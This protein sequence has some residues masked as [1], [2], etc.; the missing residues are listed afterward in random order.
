MKDRNVVIYDDSNRSWRRSLELAVRDV[1][2]GIFGS[3]SL[4]NMLAWQD[5]RQRYRRSV[6]GPFWL[7]ISTAVMVFALG[8]LYS[9]LFK[10]PLA[11]Y[12]PFVGVGLIVWNLFASI[13]NESCTVFCDAESMIKQVRQPFTM[14][15]ARMVWRNLIIFAHNFII[16][17]TILL[18]GP[19]IDYFGLIILP[20]ALLVLM[21]N[22]LWLGLFFG[23]LCTRFRDILPMVGSIV[24]ITFFITPIMWKPEI[25]TERAW[26][27]DYNPAHHFINIVRAPILGA[28]FPFESWVV[29][30]SI[31]TIGLFMSL[32]MLAKF[33][34]RIA[35]W[36]G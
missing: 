3:A 28:D 12:L 5:I 4:W 20:L 22:G 8:F 2:G 30:V 33:R 7:T 26:I 15:V 1:G 11:Q 21:V 35:Y 18:V 16:I 13:I 19:E 14:Y 32:A 25:L 17:V 34:H 27:V 10:Q 36:V 31:T 6:I 9:G 24:Q 23:V 29:V